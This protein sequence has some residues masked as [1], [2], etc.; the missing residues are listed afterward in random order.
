MT[1]ATLLAAQS[2]CHLP[3]R[4]PVGKIR[5]RCVELPGSGRSMNAPRQL[6]AL[7]AVL[8]T[9]AYSAH[10]ADRP[11]RLQVL[12]EV[13]EGAAAMPQILDPAEYADV[14]S[15]RHCGAWTAASARLLLSVRPGWLEQ[16]SGS[17]V[18]PPPCVVRAFSALR[19]STTCSA[20][21]PIQTSARWRSSTIS[22]RR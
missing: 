6:G 21:A 2:R 4:S 20:V 18:L 22:P 13:S 1:P 11:V 12:P 19:S 10:T 14:G 9:A 8:V 16:L 15:T 7:T 3:F 5:R 17:A